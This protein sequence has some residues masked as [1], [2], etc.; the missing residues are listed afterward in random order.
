MM[1]DKNSKLVMNKEGGKNPPF[2]FNGTGDNNVSDENKRNNSTAKSLFGNFRS[3]QLLVFLV[4]L[5][6]GFILQ[7][8]FIKWRITRNDRK[9][10]NIPTNATKLQQ[11]GNNIEEIN[12]NQTVKEME[13]KDTNS[14][15]DKWDQ[16]FSSGNRVVNSEKVPEIATIII[17]PQQ[18][19]RV[20][21]PTITTNRFGKYYKN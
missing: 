7:T 11:R 4:G 14:M 19:Q 3:E 12:V 20:M 1:V 9:L 15:N 10:T 16:L 18:Q 2:Y 6:F 17:T 8:L 5:G 21:I 13:T